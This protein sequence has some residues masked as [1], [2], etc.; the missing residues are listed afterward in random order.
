MGLIPL[1]DV[2]TPIPALV[3]PR[4]LKFEEPYIYQADA[5]RAVEAY[6]IVDVL[7][8]RTPNHL[9]SQRHFTS[10]M[11]VIH[12][13]LLSDVELAYYDFLAR[14]YEKASTEHLRGM[15]DGLTFEAATGG[16]ATLETRLSEPKTG[17]QAHEEIP[18]EFHL[19]Q[20]YPNP[21]NPETTIAYELAQPALVKLT[22]YNLQ[23]QLVRTLV[24]AWQNSGKY[25]VVWQGMS[26]FNESRSTSGLYFYELTVGGKVIRK[27]M[28]LLR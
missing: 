15:S 4:V 14:E 8:P 16:R 12:D 2:E 7:G 18:K 24:N 11:I 13:R 9:E 1:T 23:G 10:A 5:M 3:N 22:I 19:N 21:F 6:E 25:K 20:N 17:I 28:T 27:K 26:D